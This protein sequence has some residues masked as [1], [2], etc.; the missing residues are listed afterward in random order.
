MITSTVF[1]LQSQESMEY[2]DGIVFCNKTQSEKELSVYVS[3]TYEDGGV[4]VPVMGVYKKIGN[5]LQFTPTLPFQKG[6]AY[7]SV[8]KDDRFEF[9]IPISE[10]Y[11]RARIK[12]IYPSA[13]TLPSNLLKF[14]VHFSRP[15]SS[16]GY[17]HVELIDSD[18]K[19]IERAILKEI[20]EL[21]NDD[22]SQLT[23]WIEPGRIKRGLGPNLELG[24]VLIQDEHYTLSISSSFRDKNG[25][26]MEKTYTKNFVAG[27]DDR[28]KL[29]IDDVQLNYYESNETGYLSVKFS[30][31]VDFASSIANLIIV[32]AAKHIVNGDWR[33][34]EDSEAIFD[35]HDKLEQG[36]YQL[37]LNSVIEDLAGNNFLRNFDH[38]VGVP[39]EEGRKKQFMLSFQV[40]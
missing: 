24:P 30:E 26:P 7:I 37:L 8:C 39:V 15:M 31:A 13:D 40:R 29:K 22:Q 25:V 16:I 17:I 19:I 36:N 27:G 28:E 9:E 34:R 11:E 20:P 12:H 35:P 3:E 33:L 32:D 10:N 5:G 18:G 6:N 2:K 4:N 14:H 1:V 23:I 21:W 38:E